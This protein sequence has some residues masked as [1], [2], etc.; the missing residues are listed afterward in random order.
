MNN[1]R[2]IRLYMTEKEV[3]VV[4]SDLNFPEIECP[5][6][7]KFCTRNCALFSMKKWKIGTPIFCG[8]NQIG[9]LA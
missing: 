4:D 3:R 6:K 5:Y 1:K 2:K 8:N 9:V 7:E